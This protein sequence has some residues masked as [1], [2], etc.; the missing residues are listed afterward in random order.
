MVKRVTREQIDADLKRL[1]EFG[2]D[3]A[4]VL[5]SFSDYKALLK[6]DW[7]ELRD[8]CLTIAGGLRDGANKAQELAMYFEQ[9]GRGEND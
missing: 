9:L 8:A 2:P 3:S 4:N 6:M 5:R 1:E 7:L